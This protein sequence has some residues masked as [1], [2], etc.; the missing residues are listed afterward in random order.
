[1]SDVEDLGSPRGLS[2]QTE[3]QH[4]G[5]SHPE[6]WEIELHK[7][8][9]V[10]PYEFDDAKHGVSPASRE[11]DQQGHFSTLQDPGEWCRHRGLVFVDPKARHLG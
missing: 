1:M 5:I 11:I 6:E 3:F 10:D 7:G 9:S 4:H 8:I 2:R